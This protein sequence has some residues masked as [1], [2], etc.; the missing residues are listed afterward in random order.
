MKE[1][2]NFRIDKKPLGYSKGKEVIGVPYQLY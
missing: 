2:H 1:K